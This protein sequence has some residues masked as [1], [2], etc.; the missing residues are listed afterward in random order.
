MQ[1]LPDPTPLNHIDEEV[2]ASEV[3]LSCKEKKKN[4][5]ICVSSKETETFQIYIGEAE[6]LKGA[7]PP[8]K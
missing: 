3:V 2:E 8:V 5:Q 4:Q 6:T 1:K 7:A